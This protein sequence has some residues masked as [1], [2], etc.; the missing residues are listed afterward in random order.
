MSFS[1]KFPAGGGE[2]A[3][4][5]K[6]IAWVSIKGE[7]ASIETGTR[8]LLL[9]IAVTSAISV[10]STSSERFECPSRISIESRILRARPIIRSHAPPIWEECGGLKAHVHPSLL[11][12][13]CTF[14]SLTTLWNSSSLQAPMKLVPQSD[15]SCFAG[16]RIAKNLRSALIQLEESIDIMTSM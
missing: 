7:S 12:Y 16:P 6:S 3:F 1:E 2:P 9:I 15:C 13:L 11:M 14:V 10:Q 5:V 8:G 4:C